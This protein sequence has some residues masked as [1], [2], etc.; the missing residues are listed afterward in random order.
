VL[1]DAALPID[2]SGNHRWHYV[3]EAIG[4]AP[5]MGLALGA[6]GSAFRCLTQRLIAADHDRANAGS[7]ALPL[8]TDRLIGN[9]LHGLGFAL[10][11]WT[12]GRVSYSR[13][14]ISVDVV[15]DATADDL[16][17]WFGLSGTQDYWPFI[18]YLRRT[19]GPAAGRLEE[20]L[21]LAHGSVDRQIGLWHQALTEYGAPLLAGDPAAFEVMREIEPP[22]VE[23]RPVP[24][25]T[26]VPD[27]FLA[28]G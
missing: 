25:A 24:T 16:S 5:I 9:Y 1:P 8:L 18:A 21:E 12:F 17:I 19:D 6:V 27:A 7:G 15:G 10:D 22:A 4:T 23:S 20:A 13:D 3:V 26:W 2:S 14:R 28:R 11:S